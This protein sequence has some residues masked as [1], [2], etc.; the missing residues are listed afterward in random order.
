MSMKRKRGRFFGLLNSIVNLLAMLALFMLMVATIYLFYRAK[1]P[2]I[3]EII[4]NSSTQNVDLLYS[5]GVDR[6]GSHNGSG[7]NAI[8]FE[9]I[10]K[11]M[12]NALLATEDRRFFSHRGVDPRGV[13]RAIF[14]NLRR[15]RL[16]QGGSSITQQLSKILIGDRGRTIRRKIRELVLTME[17]EKYLTKND[18][19]TLYLAKSY[20]GAG[21]YGVVDASRFYFGKE[22]A[23]L[24]L[25]ECAML[26]G[27]LK[28]PT[29]YSPVNGRDLAI[30]R[31][32]QVIVNMQNAGFIG[33]N[34]L[35]LHIIPDLS[36][37]NIDKAAI[38]TQNRYFIDW[39][40][41]QLKELNLDK[42]ADKISVV[43]TLDSFF[44]SETVTVLDKFLEKHKDRIRNAE[45]AVLAMNRNGEILAMIGGKNYRHSQF[46]RAVYARRQTGSLFKL[47]VYL[48]GFERGLGI[49]DNFVDEPIKI[50]KWYPENYGKK[51][52]G[53]IT[54]K[55]AFMNSSNSVAVQIANYFGI[56]GVIE[57]ARKSGLDGK[58][59]NDMT[60]SLGSQENTLL[61]MVTA[62]ATVLNGG[63]PVIPHGIE[64][65]A[66]DNGIIYRWTP[67]RDLKPIFSF[68]TAEKMLFLL[69]STVSEGTGRGARLDSL[70]N[71]TTAYNALNADNRFFIGGKTGSSQNNN[72]AWFVGFANNVIIGIWIGND[73]NRPMKGIMGGNLPAE[74]WKNI[75]ESL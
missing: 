21:H 74:L 73:N 71:K 56:D 7:I 4:R 5:N 47:F 22:L 14:T 51:Y 31:M 24:N 49:N 45:V 11:D 28:A 52:E 3:D 43:T 61:E 19:I 59:R 16:V 63:I 58:F 12:V 53:R 70:V 2:T 29:K 62:Y 15:G 26:V 18:I 65:I 1:L 39:I 42:T 64:S 25:Q 44:Q 36:L 67:K 9:D 66:S 55:E 6:I 46:N 68:E 10:P 54:V 75:A 8:R 33:E 23:E 20:F 13:L 30:A 40:E 57:M 32:T 69:Y 17:L 37:E 50:G 38:Q 72:D 27:L 41:G 60:I 34:D 48:A 35:F